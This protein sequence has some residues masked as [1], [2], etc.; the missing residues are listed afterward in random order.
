MMSRLGVALIGIVVVAAFVLVADAVYP[1]R[2]TKVVDLSADKAG[3]KSEE[4]ERIVLTIECRAD[5]DLKITGLQGKKV[6]YARKLLVERDEQAGRIV[7]V[8]N[9]SV[10]RTFELTK[11]KG[12]KKC[13]FH[14]DAL[15][16]VKGKRE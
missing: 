11:D 4:G 16:P 2:E 1:E 14:W 10:T 3:K 15:E 9:D 5:G 6:D 7:I 12:L 13:P 8:L